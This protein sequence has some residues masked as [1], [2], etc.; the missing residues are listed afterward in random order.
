MPSPVR[1]VPS[2]GLL[3]LLAAIVS[4][5]VRIDGWFEAIVVAVGMAS[6]TALLSALLAIDDDSWRIGRSSPAG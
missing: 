3:V 1:I 2:S 4:P 6:I 5:G